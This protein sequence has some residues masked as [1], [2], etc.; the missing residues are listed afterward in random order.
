MPSV[1]LNPT[2]VVQSGA[3]WTNPINALPGDGAAYA[4]NASG[5]GFLYFAFPALTI[6]DG[7]TIQG[8]RVDLNCCEQYFPPGEGT[9]SI[10]A[11]GTR[12]TLTASLSKGGGALPGAIGRTG[13][14]T[15]MGAF[16]VASLGGAADLWGQ[17]WTPGDLG[18]PNFRIYVQRP[19]SLMDED[20][21]GARTLESVSLT[22][23]YSSPSTGNPGTGGNN[24]NPMPGTTQADRPNE[25]QQYL[26]GRET[27]PG[28]RTPANIRLK[29]WKFDLQPQIETESVPDYGDLLEGEEVVTFEASEASIDGYPTFDEPIPI[30]EACVGRAVVAQL[31]AGVYQWDVTLDSKSRANVQTLSGE[32]GDANIA[33]RVKFMVATEFALSTKRK[34]HGMS[35]KFIAQAIDDT[36]PL[37]A[38]GVADVQTLNTNGATAITLG[39]RG[40]R[41]ASVAAIGAGA[42]QTA[43]QGLSTV[44]AGNLLVSGTGPYTIT[45]AG[46]LAGKGLPYVEVVASTGG[47]GPVVSR[48]A[49]GG[50]ATF[51]AVPMEPGNWSAYYTANYADLGTDATK[52]TK[53]KGADFSIG[54]RFSPE[55]FMD[56]ALGPGWGIVIEDALSI[57]AKIVVQADQNATQLAADLKN[58]TP[59]YL[60]LENKGG[61]IGATGFN[62]LCQ[63]D[64]AARVKLKGNYREEGKI[65][66]REFDLKARFDPVTGLSLRIR[67]VNALPPY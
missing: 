42:L 62:H 33:E 13:N 17:S 52:F 45:G 20:Q 57:M 63:I 30:L 61:P 40:A 11:N 39:F 65:K 43:L 18:G 41:T 25:L 27:T 55:A 10:P 29:S 15:A 59:K 47:T 14:L 1:T 24:G 4:A 9:F 28:V 36:Q 58:R 21:G 8:L 48:V 54:N 23:F 22:A 5:P 6:P 51:A 49:S 37:T 16:A 7:A 60:R 50:Y 44:G 12:R 56:P 32:T 31:A 38:P 19:T 35:G 46:A 2:G 67:F 3:D 64:M 66:A 53:L 26:L 34:E